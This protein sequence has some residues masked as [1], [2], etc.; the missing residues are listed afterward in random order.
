MINN[1]RKYFIF[2]LLSDKHR[3]LYINWL[4]FVIVVVV[5]VT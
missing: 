5:V 1:V 2:E 4:F 3:S